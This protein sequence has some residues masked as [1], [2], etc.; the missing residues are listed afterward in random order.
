MSATL[1]TPVLLILWLALST[2]LWATQWT[3][4]NSDPSPGQFTS[5]QAAIDDVNV[6]AGDTLLITGTNIPYGNVTISRPITLIGAGYNPNDD[7][8]II[9]NPPANHLLR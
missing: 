2:S 3:V 5:I 7:E 1:R 8:T 9:G 6:S 4:D